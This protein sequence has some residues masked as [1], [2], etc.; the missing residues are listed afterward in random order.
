MRKHLLTFMFLAQSLVGFSQFTDDFSDGDFTTNPVWIGD[1][2]N[3]EVDSLN[4]LHHKTDT[5]S[6]ESYLVTECKVVVNAVWEFNVKL[7]FD[8]SA[9]NYSKIY[10][11]SDNSDLTSNLNGVFVK[12][13]GESGAVD[14][15]SLY[16][17]SGN[18]TAK[19]IDGVIG[20]A[21]SSPDLKIKVSRD[22]IGNWE[23][24]ADTSNQYLLQGAVF[25]NTITS[26]NYFGVYCKYTVTRSDKFWFDNFNV[27][28]TYD[29]TTSPQI[30]TND[31]IINEI[32]ADPITS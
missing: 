30:N 17:Q 4:F 27:S 29:T 21:A 2:G 6:G 1:V 20:L 22:S 11:M 7:L 14:N 16:S 8:P 24:F 26:S 31:I 23:L 12:I 28:G 18:S 13:G 32:F 9:S 19:I 3:F 10:L 5:I 15:V 25:N